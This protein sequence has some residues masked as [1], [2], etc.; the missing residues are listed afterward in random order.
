MYSANCILPLRCYF[1]L[2]SS[3]DM[4]SQNGFSI[5]FLIKKAALPAG[6]GRCNPEYIYYL[7]KYADLFSP[8]VE[9]G[10]SVV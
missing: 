6:C 2:S 3:D 4:I 7:T 9:V 10:C 5:R 1:L 8:Q